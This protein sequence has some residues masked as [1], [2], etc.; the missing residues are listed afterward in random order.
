M[1]VAVDG[2]G[3]LL[4][5]AVRKTKF[6]L[7]LPSYLKRNNGKKKIVAMISNTRH[8]ILSR[9]GSFLLENIVD[10]WRKGRTPENKIGLVQEYSKLSEN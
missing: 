9:S 6:P 10:E 2:P 3:G 1:Y 7:F 5:G 4:F 8:R